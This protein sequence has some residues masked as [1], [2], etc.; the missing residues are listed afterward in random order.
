MKVINLGYSPLTQVYDYHGTLLNKVDFRDS[1]LQSVR[2]FPVGTLVSRPLSPPP[3]KQ[4][5]PNGPKIAEEDFMEGLKEKSQGGYTIKLDDIEKA[6]KVS[7]NQNIK[8]APSDDRF[9][10]I[11]TGSKVGTRTEAE[12][13]AALG[14]PDEEPPKK[15]RSKK[16]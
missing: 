12:R 15:K 8:S 16:K 10:E 7:P 2:W 6:N 14:L 4:V 11:R 9:K 5:K 13:R 1:V 3:V